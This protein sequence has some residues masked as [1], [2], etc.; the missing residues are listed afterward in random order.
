MRLKIYLYKKTKIA[1]WWNLE[2]FSRKS[3]WYL[4]VYQ[5]WLLIKTCKAKINSWMSLAEVILIDMSRIIQIIGRTQGCR[6]TLPVLTMSIIKINSFPQT[7]VLQFIF[8]L[9]LHKISGSDIY[10]SKSKYKFSKCGPISAITNL[11]VL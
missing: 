6:Y 10:I 2:K 9:N 5:P 3:Y 1:S 11:L 8:N 7:H 4:T